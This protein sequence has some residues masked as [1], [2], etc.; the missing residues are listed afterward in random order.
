MAESFSVG[1]LCFKAKCACI[2]T[3]LHPVQWR[4]S[5]AAWEQFKREIAPYMAVSTEKQKIDMPPGCVGIYE[6]LPVYRFESPHPAV[7][8][9]GARVMTVGF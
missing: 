5:R 7:A 3:G 6:G 9:I 4:W 2:V 8:C 1:E